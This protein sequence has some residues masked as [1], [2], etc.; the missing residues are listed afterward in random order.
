MKEIAWK[1]QHRL[2]AHYLGLT[3]RGKCT[4]QVVTAIS[5]KL[6]GLIWAIG[7]HVEADTGRVKPIAA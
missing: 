6:L 5:R 7:V 1:A 4:Q 3:A 2:H